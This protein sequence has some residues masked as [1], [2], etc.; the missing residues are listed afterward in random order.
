MVVFTVFFDKHKNTTLFTK[1]SWESH[2]FTMIY[3]MIFCFMIIY[4]QKHFL[5]SAIFCKGKEIV[6][7]LHTVTAHYLR[8]NINTKCIIYPFLPHI[9]LRR[10]GSHKQ[11][12]RQQ[13]RCWHGG[14]GVG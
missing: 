9:V 7:N 1:Y 8:I 13:R 5:K 14:G 6:A 3:D 10:A 2:D 12:Y 11:V 4:Q